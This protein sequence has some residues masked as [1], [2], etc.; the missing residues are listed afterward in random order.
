MPSKYARKLMP[1][2]DLLIFSG[3]TIVGP[4]VGPSSDRIGDLQYLFHQFASSHFSSMEF[5]SNS[6]ES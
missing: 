4:F 6:I 3:S 1:G 5:E 2:Y